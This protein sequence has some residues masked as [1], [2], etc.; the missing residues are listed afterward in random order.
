[1]R[2]IQ[3]RKKR[4]S[5]KWTQDLINACPEILNAHIR[6]K[7]PSLS[8]REIIWLSPLE[9]DEFAEYRDAAFLEMLGIQELTKELNQFWPK[10]GPQWD[11]LGK[12]SD[13]TALLLIEAK[14]NVLEIVATCGAK[15]NTSLSTI[16]ERLAE[17]Q[18][19]LN[20][21]NPLIDWKSGFY[22]YANRLAHLY[23]LRQKGGKEA[24]MFFLYFM[25]DSTHIP[26]SLTVWDATLTL[27]KKLMGLSANSL[28]GNV[29]E[30][31]LNV[32]EVKTV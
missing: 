31:F 3:P 26:T 11:A 30:L 23:F 12:T 21:R 16:S 14:A 10:N 29:I 2:A 15:H 7:L 25:D 8:E 24:F 1:M 18:R 9:K 6:A 4:G 20:C 32:E 17:T 19:W 13:E 5:Q 22:Q 28:A 27:Q